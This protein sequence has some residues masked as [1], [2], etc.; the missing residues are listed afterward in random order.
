MF[1]IH[2][3]GYHTADANYTEVS[4]PGGTGNYLLLFCLKPIH[5]LLEEEIATAGENAVLIFSPGNPQ[6][7]SAVHE[8]SLSFVEFSCTADDLSLFRVPVNTIFSPEKSV[9]VDD[10]LVRMHQEYFTRDRY[11]EADLDALMRELVIYLSREIAAEELP[12]G[13]DSW[14]YRLFCQAR[15]TMLSNCEQNWG[16][17]NIPEMVTLSRS[18]FYK[19]Y[20]EFFRVSPIEDL[21]NARIEKAKFLLMNE[22]LTVTEVASLCGYSG[23]HH[24]SRTFREHT[25]LSPVNFVKA[26]TN[27]RS[28]S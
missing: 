4:R 15:Y 19:Y 27:G 14:M 20:K 23:I 7:Y 17:E 13:R 5:V 24:F 28:D 10:Y 8:Y 9:V 18:Q 22:N 16:S 12:S 21:N 2:Y 11:F 26:R 25:G 6:I 1:K 3:L